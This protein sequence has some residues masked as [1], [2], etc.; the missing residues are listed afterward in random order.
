MSAGKSFPGVDQKGVE[1]PISLATPSGTI[2][3]SLLLP[4]SRHAAVPVVL[5]IAGSGSTD[6]DGN[7]GGA[8]GQNNSLKLLALSLLEAG[9]ASVRFDKRGVAASIAAGMKEHELRLDTYVSDASHWIDRLLQDERFSGVAVVGHSEGSLIGMLACPGRP[10]KA[11]A[12]IAG[13]ARGAAS[14]LR[15]QLQGKLSP[16]LAARS[17]AILTALESGRPVGD[18]PAELEFLYRPSV[19]PYLRSWFQYLPAEAFKK[20]QMPCLIVQGDRDIQVPVSEAYA[21]KNA[22]P[23]AELQILA[24]MNHVLKRVSGDDAEQLASYVDPALPLAPDLSPHL[25]RFISNAMQK[26]K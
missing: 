11:F 26:S 7:S 14:V 18:V 8:A 4:S 12:S 22:K 3:G 1:Q 5:I 24:G 13:V 10:V 25:V 20:L 21:L 15:L 16:P 23:E 6:R 2:H 17:E 19:Q 9:F